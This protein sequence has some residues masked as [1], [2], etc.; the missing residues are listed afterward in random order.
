MVAHSL[1]AP[2]SR[3]HVSTS[4]DYRI[5]VT[6]HV[7]DARSA[8][9]IKK[10]AAYVRKEAEYGRMTRLERSCDSVSKHYVQGA[11]TRHLCTVHYTT[12][13]NYFDHA[14]P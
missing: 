10:L 11:I 4:S 8:T 12:P 13:S 14:K 9:A 6:T 7:T 5:S 2:S 1:R 3:T